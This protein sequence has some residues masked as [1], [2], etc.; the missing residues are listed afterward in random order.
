[1]SV[2]VVGHGGAGDFYP[3]NSRPSIE[4]ALELGVDRIEFDVQR[5]AGDQI[6]LVHDD[7]IWI[8]GKRHRIHNLAVNEIRRSLDGLLTLDEAIELTR[9]K[10]RLLIDI[11]SPG[12]E[13]L[14]ADA[15]N[16]AG[17][18]DQTIV[19]TTHARTLL[20]I[21]QCAPGVQ[22]GLSTGHISTVM[23]K[24]KL[25]SVTSGVLAAVTPLPFI[26]TARLIHAENL[27]LNY[28]ICSPRFVRAAH[29]S[30]LRVYAWTVNNPK[31]I[32]R[33]IAQGVDGVIS[34]RPDLVQEALGLR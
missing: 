17:I 2:E 31:P 7:D 5:A 21:R 13:T 33:L 26:T 23:R 12:Y 15:I 22:L 11:K 27:M 6:V 29:R 16:S 32:Q 34:N 14:V 28:R 8:D 1:M 4:K 9:G 10:C 18:A 30:G 25:I 3:G 24:N 20:R 19:S